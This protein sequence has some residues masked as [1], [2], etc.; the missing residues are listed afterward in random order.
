LKYQGGRDA[1]KQGEK[2]MVVLAKIALASA[3]AIGFVQP[4]PAVAETPSIPTS[5]VVGTFSGSV[6]SLA[7]I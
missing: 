3:L 7:G 6:G 4:S 1:P 2:I 5:V